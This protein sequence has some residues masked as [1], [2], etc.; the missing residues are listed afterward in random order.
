MGDLVNSLWVA[1]RGGRL[2]E[3]NTLLKENRW[4][5]HSVG[6]D[7]GTPLHGAAFFGDSAAVSILLANGALVDAKDG[8]GNTPLMRAVKALHIPVME[9]LLD[10][11]ADFNAENTHGATP[12]RAL[13]ARMNGRDLVNRFSSP[14]GAE[15]AAQQITQLLDR[16]GKASLR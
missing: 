13:L 2:E 12:M 14:A 4:L 10:N 7:G 1:L 11:G 15:R 3:L 16:H 5:V 9:V 8:E 6:N